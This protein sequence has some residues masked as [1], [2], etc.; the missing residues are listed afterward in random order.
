MK[1]EYTETARN[2]PACEIRLGTSSWDD[3]KKS[4]KYAWTNS[5][6]KIARGGEVPVEALPQM[7]DFAIRKEYLPAD[8]S[9]A[10]SSKGK[11]PSVGKC[12]RPRMKK[13]MTIKQVKD[14]YREY[15]PSSSEDKKR[16]MKNYKKALEDAGMSEEEADEEVDVWGETTWSNDEWRDYY[17]LEPGDDFP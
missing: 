2:D 4:V 6:G 5:D 12:G 8:V 17:G 14:E 3:S 7:L 9:N 11:K 1:T 16:L 13:T 15:S 10:R